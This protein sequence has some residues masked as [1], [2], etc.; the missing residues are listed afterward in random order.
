[1]HSKNRGES[2]QIL[3]SDVKSIQN[4]QE[5][6]TKLFDQGKTN[7]F[8]IFK[9]YYCNYETN[10]EREYQCHVVLKHPGKLAYPSEI[11]LEKMGIKKCEVR[12]EQTAN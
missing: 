6:S 8:L 12:Y 5:Q 9:C 2:Q 3:A 10:I 7:N 11:D 1:L 4:E